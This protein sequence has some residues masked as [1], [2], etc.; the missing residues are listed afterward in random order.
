MDALQN[1]PL[2]KR[3]RRKRRNLFKPAKCK[4]FLVKIRFICMRIKNNRYINGF[5]LSLTLK[6]RLG[7]S[8]S[9]L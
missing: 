4:T 8:R 6:Q 3:K 7:A 2:S 1:S 9:K 5:I